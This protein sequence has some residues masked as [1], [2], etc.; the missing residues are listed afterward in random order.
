MKFPRKLEKVKI[1]RRYKRFFADVESKSKE[2]LTV[3]LPN[4][5][6]ML[7]V[8]EPGRIAYIMSKEVP[9]KLS[10]GVEI[11]HTGQ[12]LVGVNTMLPN[13]LFKEAKK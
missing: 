11:V 7:G 13:R 6:P 5:G 9:K 2:T 3:H 10:H 12:S 4:T 1:I 8:W